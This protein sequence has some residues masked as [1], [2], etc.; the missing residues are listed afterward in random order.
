[1][2]YREYARMRLLDELYDGMSDEEKR[3]FIKL[4]MQ[5]KD[6][7][8]IMQALNELKKKAD[9]NHH[10]FTTDLAANVSGNAIWELLTWVGRRLFIK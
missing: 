1:M 5:N 9:A 8:E 6:H 7:T 3:L 2:R 4:T 10:S